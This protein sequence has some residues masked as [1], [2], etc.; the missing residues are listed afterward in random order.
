MAQREFSTDAHNL[1]SLLKSA[2]ATSSQSIE[3]IRSRVNNLRSAASTHY[4]SIYLLDLRNYS[5]YFAFWIFLFLSS[6]QDYC[7]RDSVRIEAENAKLRTEVERLRQNLIS[8]Q[9][10]HG[11]PLSPTDL[12]VLVF[13]FLSLERPT[14]NNVLVSLL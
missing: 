5:R 2:S 7:N 4:I 8:L 1:V 13:S 9:I 10:L 11:G 14:L 12:G 6:V 3:E